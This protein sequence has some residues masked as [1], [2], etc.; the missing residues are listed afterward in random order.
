MPWKTP[1]GF[2]VYELCHP[3]TG[4]VFYVGKGKGRRALCHLEQVIGGR[5][6]NLGK[7]K[8]IADIVALGAEPEIRIAQDGMSHPAALALERKMI[9]AGAS[10]TNIRPGEQTAAQRAAASLAHLRTR[11]KPFDRWMRERP[12]SDYEITAYREIVEA[13]DQMSEAA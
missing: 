10:L 2:Y 3:L 1:D 11:I 12:R 9:A 8:I 4:A 13:I 6:Q 7:A 5:S